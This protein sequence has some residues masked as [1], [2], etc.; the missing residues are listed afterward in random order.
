VNGSGFGRFSD[1]YS[2]HS[3]NLWR[4]L[5]RIG[6]DPTL[7]EDLGQEAF[8]RWSLSQAVSWDDERSRA[9]LFTIG[10]RL[11]TDWWRRQSRHSAWE[12]TYEADPAAEI[13]DSPLFRSRAWAALTRRQQQLLWLAYVEEFSH[14]EI[15]GICGIAPASVRVLLSRSRALIA[16][17]L[18][19]DNKDEVHE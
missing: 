10:T 7:A 3:R 9:Y 13:A 2:R 5:V 17:K 6:A 16:G 12:A 18:T 14:A 11:L 8:L 1:F 19:E 15:A 4:Y